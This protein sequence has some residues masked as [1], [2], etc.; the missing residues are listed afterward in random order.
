MI[1]TR[2]CG[3]R[4][5]ASP[6]KP[7]GHGY[8]LL[9]G[10]PDPAFDRV[11]AYEHFCGSV[12]KVALVGGNQGIVAR[13][14]DA[15]FDEVKGHIVAKAY[16]L[17]DSSYIMVA[18]SALAQDIK[19]QVNLG[20][21]EEFDAFHKADKGLCFTFRISCLGFVLSFFVRFVPHPSCASW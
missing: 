13:H 8:A 5:A 11:T 17:E 21:G 18:V 10:Y 20:G 14:L 12:G 16:F 4:I 6:T 1:D 19:A 7:R 3:G 2:K 15:A 9:N